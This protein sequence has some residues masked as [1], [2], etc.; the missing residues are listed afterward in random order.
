MSFQHFNRTLT[1]DF[2][3]FVDPLL[4]Q[5]NDLNKTLKTVSNSE[6][7]I[8]RFNCTAHPSDDCKMAYIDYKQYHIVPVKAVSPYAQTKYNKS[9]N[10]IISSISRSDE[11]WE[12]L[13]DLRENQFPIMTTIVNCRDMMEDVKIF[14]AIF[15]LFKGLDDREEIFTKMNSATDMIKY[16]ILTDCHNKVVLCNKYLLRTYTKPQQ[17]KRLS[18]GNNL[19]SLK[20]TNKVWERKILQAM[21]PT[22]KC[23][24]N[25]NIPSNIKPW[26]MYILNRE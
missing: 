23:A 5:H 25:K 20:Y 11:F 22:L 15:E 10:P 6:R 9:S 24:K 18:N 2:R 19:S 12:L 21:F 8:T 4:I 13:V 16:H 17:L 3:Q 1:N 26:V 7:Q 14:K